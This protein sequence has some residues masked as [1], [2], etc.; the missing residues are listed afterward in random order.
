MNGKK[1]NNQC[2]NGVELFYFSSFLSSIRTRKMPRKGAR[3]KE[4]SFLLL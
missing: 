4:L 1:Y 2:K 3:L